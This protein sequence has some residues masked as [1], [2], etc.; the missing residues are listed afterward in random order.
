MRVTIASQLTPHLLGVAR[1]VV[2]QERA[3]G[4]EAGVVD[5]QLD[6]DAELG[7]PL[8]QRRR[9]GGEVAGDD[10]RVG[11]KLG[12]EALQAVGP[13]G[14]QHQVVPAGGELAGELLANSRRG[15]GD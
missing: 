12:G 13:A 3:G 5:Q 9:V 8:R 2:L 11:R 14:D 10:V 4:A 15:A 6:L 7:D 1:R